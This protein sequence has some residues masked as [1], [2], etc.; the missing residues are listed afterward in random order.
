MQTGEIICPRR[1]VYRAE[2]KEL[3]A[4]ASYSLIFVILGLAAARPLMVN[5]ILG[6]AEAYATLNLYDDAKRQCDKALLLDNDNSE[7]WCKLAR[8]YRFEGDREMAYGAYEKA[9]QADA[10]NKPAHYELGMM[11]AQDDRFQEAIPYFDQVRKLGPDKPSHPRQDGFR[12]HKASME[13]LALCYEQTDNAAKAEFTHEEIKVFYP[14]YG[15]A[16]TQL[17]HLKRRQAE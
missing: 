12:Y 7:A 16:D 8:I 5:H 13:M 17:A 11:Y 15:A 3:V 14:D 9:T 6:R 1:R 10:A 2:H 4:R